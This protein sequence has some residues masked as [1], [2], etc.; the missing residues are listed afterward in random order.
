M[1]TPAPD[2]PQL[3]L[4][5]KVFPPYLP[6]STGKTFLDSPFTAFQNID[7]QTFSRVT[8]PGRNAGE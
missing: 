3:T 5:H 7:N 8:I 2:F 4:D 6:I 1:T